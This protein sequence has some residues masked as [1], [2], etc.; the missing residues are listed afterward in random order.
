MTPIR[1]S[2]SLATSII[3]AGLGVFISLRTTAQPQTTVAP[4]AGP[5]ASTNEMAALRAEVEILKAKASDQA[6]VMVSVAYH[7]GNLWFAAQKQNWPL[8]EFY[9]LET[10]AH[11]RWATRVIPVRKDPEGNEVRLQEILD[12]IERSV[13]E[14]LRKSIA[15]KDLPQF[16]ESYEQMLESCHACHLVSGKPFLRL[17]IPDRPPEPMIRFE[18]QP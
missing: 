17:R 12:P 7:F 5:P 15:G 10:R 1:T 3:L 9:W 11:M 4:T 6:H 13:F 2:I 16:K 14:D 8:A 18:P